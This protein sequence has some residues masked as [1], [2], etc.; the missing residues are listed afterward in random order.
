MR[1]GSLD[2][3]GTGLEGLL[4]G[5][6]EHAPPAPVDARLDTRAGHPPAHAHLSIRHVT[7][8]VPALVE[9]LEDE[10]EHV[11]LPGRGLAPGHDAPSAWRAIWAGRMPSS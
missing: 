8:A 10:L 6:L 9:P 2:V 3:M 7:D 5:S 11:A 1:A 4:E